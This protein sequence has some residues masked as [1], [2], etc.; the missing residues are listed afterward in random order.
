MDDP[1]FLRGKRVQPVEE[2]LDV[3]FVVEPMW[4]DSH[5]IARKRANV[6]CPAAEES[7]KLGRRRVL[8]GDD[9]RPHPALAGCVDAEVALQ[10]LVDAPI[11]ERVDLLEDHPDADLQEQ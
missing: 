10:Q 3:T 4:V 2:A 9:A 6:Y 5:E 11:H 8:E 1:A 7:E